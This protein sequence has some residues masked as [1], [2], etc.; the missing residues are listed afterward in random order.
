MTI[1]TFGYR[2]VRPAPIGADIV[3][4]ARCLHED[5]AEKKTLSGLTGEDAPVIAY[6]STLPDVQLFVSAMTAAL[7]GSTCDVAAV[8]CHSGRHRSVYIADTV[9]KAIGATVVHL[10]MN[11]PRPNPADD[12]EPDYV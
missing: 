3:F 6:L 4:D 10:D 11:R 2:Y 5:P 8:A 7:K 12:H 1:K 9:A